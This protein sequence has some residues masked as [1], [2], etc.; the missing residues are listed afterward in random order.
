MAEFLWKRCRDERRN[1]GRR[2]GFGDGP[3]GRPVEGQVLPA[4]EGRESSRRQNVTLKPAG[5]STR[6]QLQKVCLEVRR[7]NCG[8]TASRSSSTPG[9]CRLIPPTSKPRKQRTTAP[10]AEQHPELI[11]ALQALGLAGVTAAQVDAAVKEV[12]PQG[13]AGVDQAEVVRA[14][15]LHLRRRNSVR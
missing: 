1:K 8:A 15:F 7:R 3:H 6:K 4:S 11:E 9:E 12:Y 2:Y 10:K 13:T 14:V 5:R